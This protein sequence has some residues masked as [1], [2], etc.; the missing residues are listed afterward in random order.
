MILCLSSPPYLSDASGRLS[1]KARNIH[2]EYD[3]TKEEKESKNI[4]SQ[5]TSY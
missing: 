1:V 2:Q 5:S 4:S 3:A